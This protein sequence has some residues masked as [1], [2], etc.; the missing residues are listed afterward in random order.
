MWTCRTATKTGEALGAD[1]SGMVRN[2]LIEPA[3][4]ATET[5]G[6]VTVKSDVEPS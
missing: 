5:E 1:Y 2:S 6:K 3:E 4:K